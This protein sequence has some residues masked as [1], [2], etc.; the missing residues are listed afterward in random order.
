VN[1]KEGRSP[2][3]SAS[4]FR[5]NVDYRLQQGVERRSLYRSVDDEIAA[6][7]TVPSESCVG[8]KESLLLIRSIP[9]FPPLTINRVAV[10]PEVILNAFDV[11]NEGVGAWVFNPLGRFYIV[12]D[13]K[14]LYAASGK[15]R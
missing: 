15:V 9:V 8:V 11:G 12:F 6:F 4:D 14:P 3:L 7:H 5:L 1:L 2:H 10:I 13:S